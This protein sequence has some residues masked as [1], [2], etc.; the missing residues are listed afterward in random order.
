MMI[1]YVLSYSTRDKRTVYTMHIAQLSLVL[2]RSK[3]QNFL[4]ILFMQRKMLAKK[5][6]PNG[7]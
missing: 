4:R 2:L 7:R 3:M 1:T 6:F 5:Y